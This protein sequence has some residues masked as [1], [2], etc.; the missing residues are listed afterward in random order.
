MES[1]LDIMS[2]QLYTASATITFPQSET[3]IMNDK[4]V[5]SDDDR[6]SWPYLEMLVFGSFGSV[7]PAARRERN[8]RYA[9]LAVFAVSAV[10]AASTSLP[11]A[12]RVMFAVAVP[13]ALVGLIWSGV[14]YLPETDELTRLLQ[15]EAAAV[16]YG[17]VIV[18]ASIW[19]ALGVLDVFGTPPGASTVATLDGGRMRSVWPLFVLLVVVEPIRGLALVLLARSRR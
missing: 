4:R 17:A 16:A 19:Y 10:A 15:L 3:T 1:M 8:V 6:S 9:W 2:R 13:M 12:A 5:E 18:L 11:W 14:K 7:T